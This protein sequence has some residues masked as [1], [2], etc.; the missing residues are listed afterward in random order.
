MSYPKF[1][2]TNFLKTGV[3]GQST[4][5]GCAGVFDTQ[6]GANLPPKSY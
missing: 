5:P 6:I 4:L 1:L 3:Q 2:R